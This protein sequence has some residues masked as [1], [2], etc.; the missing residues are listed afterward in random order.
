VVESVAPVV[1]TLA[2]N[3]AIEISPDVM[4]EAIAVGLVAL[5]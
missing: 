1:L 5:K 3:T 2:D 4:K